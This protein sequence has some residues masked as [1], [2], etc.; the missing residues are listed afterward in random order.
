MVNIDKH[1]SHWRDGAEEDLEVA[2]QLITSGKVRHGLFFL[3]LAL[4]KMLKAHVCRHTKDIAPRLHN[5]VR[6][7]A[8][9]GIPFENEQIAFLAEMNPYNLEGR[10]PEMWEEPPSQEQTKKI[11][12]VTTEMFKWLMT[13]L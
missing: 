1:I 11:Q 3:H 13:Q 2:N 9:S 12:Q 5:L 10:Y 4:E 8:L 7:A 6:L